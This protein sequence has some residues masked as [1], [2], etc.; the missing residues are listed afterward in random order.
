MAGEPN[1]LIATPCY[2]GLVTNYFLM[3]LLNLTRTLTARGIS[4]DFRTISDSLITRARNHI[5]NEFLREGG[6]THLFFIDADLGF[7]AEPLLRFLE[8]DKDLVCGV[9]PLKRL[10]IAA[11]RAST[12]ATDQIAEAASYTYSSSL[13]INDGNRPESGF[14]RADFAATGFMLIRRRVLETMAEAYPALR[15][16]GDHT[17]RVGEGSKPAAKYAFFDTMIADGEHLPEDYSF[18][19]R[20]RDIGGEIW[21]DLESRFQHVGSHVFSGDLGLAIGEA[22][23]LGQIA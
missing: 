21:I 19:K 12:A 1:I 22:Q 10:S 9:Y 13:A 8:F 20:W 11:L 3:S 14:L 16:G 7:E 18:C 4:Y 17:M 2:G 23:R 6:F 15:Y 5:A